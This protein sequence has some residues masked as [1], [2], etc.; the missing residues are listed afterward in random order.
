MIQISKIIISLLLAFAGFLAAAPAAR[1]QIG[2]S[3]EPKNEFGVWAG[4]SPDSP[5]VIGT[6]AERQLGLLA[7]R[8]GRTLWENH[9][10]SLQYTVDI[11]PLELVLQPKITSVIF[12]TP[13]PHNT[14]VQG[15]RE[16]VY[17][18]GINPIGLK[19]NFRRSNRL[20]PFVA[21]TAGFIASVHRVPIDVPGGTLFNFQFDFQ[22]GVQRYNSSHTGA[23]ML[24]YKL[25]H[26]SNANRATLNPGMDGHVIFLG[27]SIFR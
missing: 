20:Q 19:M 2:E 16:Y 5:H 7:V 3:F 24:G 21:S 8:Y 6:T 18:G 14:F 25:I 9:S 26:I 10:V 17:G 15:H 23:W 4:Y 22:A 13:P 27:Y 1:C 11:L 12:T